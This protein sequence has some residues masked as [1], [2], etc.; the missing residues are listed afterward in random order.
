VLTRAD[1]YVQAVLTALAPW[2]KG[3]WEG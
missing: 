3:Q 2:Y 1:A